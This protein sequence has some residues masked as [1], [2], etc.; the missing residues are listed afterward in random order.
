MS[1][2]VCPEPLAGVAE[3]LAGRAS[4]PY[5]SAIRPSSHSEGE[6]PSCNSSEEVALGKFFKVIWMDIDNAPVVN[7]A[8][9][10]QAAFDEFPEPLGRVFI[11]LIVISS[12]S[13]FRRIV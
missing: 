8:V 12:Q 2:V 13:K 9:W 6:R 10:Y 7:I 11:P 3:G 1:G 5:R 4:C